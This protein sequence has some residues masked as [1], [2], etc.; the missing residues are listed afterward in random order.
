M[1][2]QEQQWTPLQEAY[3]GKLMATYRANL[4]FLKERFPTLFSRLMA[5]EIPVPFEVGPGGAVTL[6]SGRKYGSLKEF[7]TLGHMLLDIFNDEKSRPSVLVDTAY[8]RDPDLIVAHGAN[9]DFYRPIEHTFRGELLEKFH[10]LAGADA[11]LSG[12]LD[13]GPRHL[14]LALVFGSG[15]GWHLDRLVDDYD[16][17][18]LIILDTAIAR[19]NLSL[20]FVDYVAL[21]QRFSA[22]GRLFL[23]GCHEDPEILARS[24]LA[25]IQ[26]HCP[27]YILQGAGLFVEEYDSDRVRKIYDFL[28]INIWTLYRGWGFLDDEILG[29]KQALENIADHW[30][31]FKGKADLPP[32]AV[33]FV[34]G[35]GPSLDGLLPLIRE[36]GDRAVVICC[37]SALSALANAGIKP[38]FHLMIERQHESY[39]VLAIPETREWL[40]DVPIVASVIMS[41]AVFTLSDTPLLFLK[42][43]DFG[44]SL[45]DFM[46]EWPRISTNPTVTN[47]GV[48]FALQLGFREVYLCGIDLGYLDPERH[49]ASGSFYHSDKEKTE[50]V[51][52]IVEAA[53]A[54]YADCRPVPGNFREEVQTVESFVYCRDV[55]QFSISQHPGAKVY[56]LSDGALI[57]GATPQRPEGFSLAIGPDVRTR[58]LAAVHGAFT[59]DYGADVDRNL[60]DLIIQLEA[61]MADLKPMLAQEPRDKMSAVGILADIHYYFYAHVNEQVEAQI[62]PLVRGAMQHLGRF[63]FD[64]IGR[65]AD[66]EKACEFA[67]FALGLFERFLLAGR[68]NLKSLRGLS[69]ERRRG[70]P[71]IAIQRQVRV[72]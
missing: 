67:R 69:G 60:D 36:Y 37:G 57:Q 26:Q 5:S 31:L 4:Y 71:S 25:R 63:T 10:E 17:A 23:V 14:P 43:I 61:L 49:H 48:D 19:F 41:P 47:G 27:P 8:M 29:A 44:S 22:R 6:Y 9:P 59:R 2:D 50:E 55:M 35:S 65:I 16:I 51:D 54:I 11:Q 33:A 70:N 1:P 46:R 39:R 58:A 52:N 62:Y 12:R 21:E 64:C 34:V 56:N 68:D 38:D 42:A 7:T 53:K 45:V 3:I 24:L 40:K 66:E 15:F 20:Y 30:P 28:R 13:F 72:V 32:D 18:H